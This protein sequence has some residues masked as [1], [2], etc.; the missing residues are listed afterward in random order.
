MIERSYFWSQLYYQIYKWQEFM[1]YSFWRT[2][3]QNKGPAFLSPWDKTVFPVFPVFPLF[4]TVNIR[5]G[6]LLLAILFKEEDFIQG[7]IF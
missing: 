4:D 7:R 2:S 1:I 5:N 3:T 6:K